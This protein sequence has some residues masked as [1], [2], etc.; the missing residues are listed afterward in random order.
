MLTRDIAHHFQEGIWPFVC[1]DFFSDDEIAEILTLCRSLDL[2]DGTVGRGADYEQDSGMRR[3]EVGF[4]FD[5]QAKWM[6]ERLDLMIEMLNGTYFGYDLYG[7]DRVQYA[8]YGSGGHYNWHSD[9][10]S[11]LPVTRKLSATILL[12][13]DFDG[14]QFQL[15]MSSEDDAIDVELAKGQ[16]VLFPSH[17][18]HRV[19]PVT[20]G[21]RESLVVW[22]FGP[23][24]R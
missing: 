12:S 5:D 2:T 23:K 15:N 6:F 11:K 24:L 22:V 18:L 21:V 20:R 1:C 8:R 9:V 4:I 3:S 13:D 19:K 14:G 10:G 7:Y 17:T 16:M